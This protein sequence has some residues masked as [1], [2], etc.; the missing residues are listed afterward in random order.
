MTKP[1]KSNR[2]SK[3]FTRPN[4]RGRQYILNDPKR[5]KRYLALDW[6][7]GISELAKETGL[8]RETLSS[9]ARP[10]V[11]FYKAFKDR[12]S[13]S[14]KLA[15]LIMR[16]KN[17]GCCDLKPAQFKGWCGAMGIRVVK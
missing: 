8:S 3:A 11:M 14:Y 7:K 5:L 17:R 10:Q 1:A 12:K 2:V 16:D 13:L 6:S 4:P 15:V 9:Y